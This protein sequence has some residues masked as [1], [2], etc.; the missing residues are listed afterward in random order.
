MTKKPKVI[1]DLDIA[2]NIIMYMQHDRG[3]MRTYLQN[4][5]SPGMNFQY[6][7]DEEKKALIGKLSE[8][9]I[10]HIL[11]QIEL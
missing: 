9:E 8:R 1:L 3:F 7:S 10:E 2:V 4:K 5:F 6:L 11:E